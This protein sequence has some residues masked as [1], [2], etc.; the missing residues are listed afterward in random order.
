MPKFSINVFI[1][2]FIVT[3]L[4]YGE[5]G[6]KSNQFKISCEFF[7]FSFFENNHLLSCS[8]HNVYNTNKEKII[9]KFVLENGF[10]VF[11]L[12]LFVHLIFLFYLHF[13]YTEILLGI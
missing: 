3:W 8:W 1:K 11:F 5:Y 7:F 10:C 12:M 4:P 2:V 6:E 13:L 9:T